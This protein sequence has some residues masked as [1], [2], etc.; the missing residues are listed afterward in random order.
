MKNTHSTPHNVAIP[1]A[2][3]FSSGGRPQEHTWPVDLN[4]N[5]VLLTKNDDAGPQP[6]AFHHI[7][8]IAEQTMWR[9]LVQQKRGLP[10]KQ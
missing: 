7:F 4:K 3:P 1:A 10:N 2:R 8:S 6:S 9:D 5:L